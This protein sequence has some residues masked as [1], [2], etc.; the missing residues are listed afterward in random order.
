VHFSLALSFDGAFPHFGPHSQWYLHLLLFLFVFFSFFDHFLSPLLLLLILLLLQFSSS[1]VSP[2]FLTLLEIID[3]PQNHP[4][5]QSC[6]R[7]L[8]E[9]T[10]QDLA[11][12][13]DHG[14]APF[15]LFFFLFI[16]LLFLHLLLLLLSYCLDEDLRGRYIFAAAHGAIA[17]MAFDDQD[18]ALKQ[19][20]DKIADLNEFLFNVQWSL[21]SVFSLSLSLSLS[22]PLPPFS[23]FSS[24]LPREQRLA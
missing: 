10:G 4:V 21:I 5:I 18:K 7:I 8:S 14:I 6:A 13:A 24:S 1:F 19:F 16:L 22:L 23:S 15:P 2:C 9:I 3:Q 20:H 11:E 12:D 17:L